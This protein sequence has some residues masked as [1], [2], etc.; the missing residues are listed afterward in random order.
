MQDPLC[1]SA[2]SGKSLIPDPE[3][4]AGYLSVPLRNLGGSE[5]FLYF[6]LL[7]VSLLTLFLNSL[8]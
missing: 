5:I 8:F 7:T 2:Q 4:N 1:F 3:V 6:F